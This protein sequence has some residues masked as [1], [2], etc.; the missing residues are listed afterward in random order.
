MIAGY[1]N[2]VQQ[3]YASTDGKLYAGAGATL[4]DAA[5]ISVTAPSVWGSNDG[6]KFASSGVVHSGL[7]GHKDASNNKIRLYSNASP[8]YTTGYFS[9]VSAQVEI[10]A[11][12]K[13]AGTS[14]TVQL[15]ATH[16]SYGSAY[17]AL[18]TNSSGRQLFGTNIDTC[19]INGSLTTMQINSYDVWHAGNDGSGSGLDADK[20][21]SY[22][23]T[24]FGRLAVARTWSALQTFD[25]SLRI[26][27]DP[28][29]G[30]ASKL[31]LTNSFSGVS[32]GAGTVK[33]NGTTY[34][35]SAGWIKM[36]NGTTAIY[37]PYWTT[38]TG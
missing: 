32:T 1:N 23:E 6:Y 26:G 5:G 9:G 33:M 20:L 3:W 21:D 15:S 35:D 31:T 11:W 30:A 37:V 8:S 12:S 25:A 10:G 34:R 7:W 4:I 16:D 17:L 36:Y 22:E 24:S 18:V 13:S 27:A 28:G 38:I 19:Y 2:N 14:S 29:S